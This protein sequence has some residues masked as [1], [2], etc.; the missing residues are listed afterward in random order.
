MDKNKKNYFLVRNRILGFSVVIISLF[1]LTSNPALGWGD[2][3]SRGD[4]V[5]GM[6]SIFSNLGLN[7]TELKYFIKNFNV[8]RRKKQQPLVSIKFDPANPIPGQKVGAVAVP[9]YFMNDY[10][11]LYFTWYL[12]PHGCP[13]GKDNHPSSEEKAKC[14]ADK[15]GRIDI[16]DYKVIAMRKLANNDFEWDKDNA[17]VSNTDDDGYR[18]VWGG[19]D[20][21]GKP[22]SC[23]VHDM[24]SGNEYEIDCNDHLFPDAPDEKTGDSSFSLKEEKFWHTD[25]QD[26]DTAD[27]GNGDE[28]NIAGLGQTTFSWIYEPGDAIGVVVEGISFEA[29]QE[30]N[31]SYKTMWALLNNDCDLGELHTGYPLV[32]TDGPTTEIIGNCDGGGDQQRET[33]AEATE[34]IVDRVDNIATIRTK[35]ITTVK[36]DSDCNGTYEDSEITQTKVSTCPDGYTGTTAPDDD[37]ATCSG[38]DEEVNLKKEKV[39]T[40][41]RKSSDLNKCLYNNMIDPMEGGGKA[42]KLQVSLSANPELPINNPLD[43][44]AASYEETDGDQLNVTATV[45]NP[46]NEGFLKYQWEVYV[47]DT[48]N[49]ES[50]GDPVPKQYLLH[51]SPS[52]GLGV[53]AFNF[54]LNL[55]NDYLRNIRDLRNSNNNFYLKVK[56]TVSE[57]V[58][59]GV[60]NSSQVSSTVTREGHGEI[61]LPVSSSASRIK[62]FTTNAIESG[63]DVIL[64]SSD[65]EIC[66]S[67]LERTLCPI[68]KNKIITLRVDNGSGPSTLK[69]FSWSINGKVFGPLSPDCLSGECHK[70]DGSSTNIAYLAALGEPGTRYNVIFSAITNKGER[71]RL[72][73]VFEV[74]DPVVKILS[75]D[76]NVAK[77]VLLGHYIDL[78]GI[79]WPDY[80]QEKFNALADEYIQLYPSS[81][82]MTPSSLEWYV[83]GILIDRDNASLFDYSIGDDDNVLVMKGKDLDQIDNVSLE[84]TFIVDP[85]TK[86]A[87]VKYWD[88]TYT[89]FYDK[90]FT[91]DIEIS[92]VGSLAE[93]AG[94]LSQ[95]DSP[96]K[97]LASVISAA[98]EY[99]AF[100][101]R[102]VLTSFLMLAF[103]KVILSLFPYIGTEEK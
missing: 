33:T 86:K 47:S 23:F 19:D 28:A 16:E 52:F 53:D 72:T 68:T 31:T 91:Q 4:V 61:I 36:T 55:T 103:S 6:N 29:T 10:D 66:G 58:P 32:T 14:D 40:D 12:K 98:P 92:Y 83:N 39:H 64:E 65:D 44:S 94:T 9:L 102:V 75:A 21:K 89:D 3:I 60:S 100:L 18:A 88:A 97:V 54:Q 90:P 80:S 70:A 63:E 41:I 95:N 5:D 101:F 79:Y 50:W 13:D 71:I 78:D 93:A 59:Q 56:A 34:Y 51:S 46:E 26:S 24:K 11:D 67:G 38:T 82:G 22:H 73:K 74:Q 76:E 57:N 15:N 81:G 45:I 1:S 20:Q 48:P 49:P 96:K 35:T 62:S 2:S 25:P 27:T 87:L 84:A 8:S 42:T 69:N 43:P 37:E 99:L 77:P 85:I 7:K 17:Y 30:K